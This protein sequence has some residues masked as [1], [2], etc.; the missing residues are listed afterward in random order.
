M[1]RKTTNLTKH[2][3]ALGLVAIAALAAVL[4]AGAA[5]VGSGH[6]ALANS[7]NKTKENDGI[8]I[9][10]KTHQKQ[11]CQTAGATSP[12]TAFTI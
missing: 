7:G 11:E 1:N 6:M 5:A 3:A 10:T 12:I 2:K 8:S 9:P 4:V